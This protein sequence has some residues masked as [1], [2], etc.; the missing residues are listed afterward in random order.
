[1]INIL[2]EIIVCRVQYT[3]T[4]VCNHIYFVIKSLIASDLLTISYYEYV[5]AKK[6]E[7]TYI[8]IGNKAPPYCMHA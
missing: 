5:T 4:E 1:M 2:Y 8:Y 7:C 3:L 6:I